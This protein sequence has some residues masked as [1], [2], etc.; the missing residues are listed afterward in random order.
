MIYRVVLDDTIDLHTSD[1]NCMLLNPS[2][3]LEMNSAGSF[4]FT[5]PPSHPYWD[6]IKVLKSTIDVYED[7]DLIFTGRIASIEKNWNNERVVQCEGALAYFNDSIHRQMKWETPLPIASEDPTVHN[8]LKDILDNHNVFEGAENANRHIFIGNITVDPEVVT[9]EV[10]YDTTLDILTRMCIDT[11][12]GYMSVR[13]DLNDGKLYLDWI[14]DFTEESG[15]PAQFGL[16]LLNFDTSL[17]AEDICTGVLAR[18]A[19]V[20][21]QTVMLNDVELVDET[22]YPDMSV[23]HYTDKYQD[24]LWHREGVEKFGQVVQVHDFSDAQTAWKD[25]QGQIVANSLFEMAKKW[26]EEKNT[27]IETIEVE[28]AELAW[29]GEGMPKYKLGQIVELSDDVHMAG[30]SY[31]TRLLPMYKLSCDLNSGSKKVT[32]GTPPKKELTQISASNSD[33]STLSSSGSSSGSGGSGEGEECRV[34]D[35]RVDGTSVVTNKIANI[36]LTG[37]ADVSTVNALAVTVASKADT[38]TVNALATVVASKQDQIE[39]NT[40]EAATEV[41]TRLKANNVVYNLGGG[42]EVEA[43]PSDPAT[44]DLNTIKIGDTVYDIPGSGGS[45]TN[46][47]KFKCDVLFNTP[48]TTSSWAS[49]I[50]ICS[51]EKAKE[52]DMIYLITEFVDGASSAF[53]SN[54]YLVNSIGQA[55]DSDW[56]MGIRSNSSWTN[57]ESF[58]FLSFDDSKLKFYTNTGNSSTLC[59]VYGLKFENKLINR[60]DIYSEE[61]RMIGRW[62]DGKPLYQKVLTIPNLPNAT[63]ADYPHGIQNVD[64][65]WVS[66]GVAKN[67][68]TGSSCQLNNTASNN[69][70]QW[71]TNADRTNVSIWAGTDRRAFDYVKVILKYTKTTDAPNSGFLPEDPQMVMMSDYYSEDEQ[72]IGRWTDGKPLY[73][74]VVDCGYGPNSGVKDVDLTALNVDNCI[75]IGGYMCA[76]NTSFLPIPRV[77]DR[78]IADQ[79][80]FNYNN[81]TKMLSIT[82]RDRDMT[83]IHIIAI[84]KYTKTTDAPGTGP[85]KGNLIYLPALYSEEEREVGVWTDGKPIYQKNIPIPAIQSAQSGVLISNLGLNID[86]CVDIKV[87]LYKDTTPDDDTVIATAG[88]GSMYFYYRKSEDSIRID[89]PFSW[90]VGRYGNLTIQYTKTTDQPGS[91]TWTPEGQLAHHYSTS[92]KIV[93]TWI[94]GSTI[95]EKTIDFGSDITVNN[96]WQTTSELNTNMDK[97]ISAIF[98]SSSGNHRTPPCVQLNYGSYIRICYNNMTDTGRYLTLQYTKSS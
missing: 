87:R 29:L 68:Q 97:C 71:V 98:M 58:I 76:S 26:L 6:A 46:Y 82:C 64:N 12:G 83:S 15:Q 3:D 56:M 74:K 49:P 44:D 16:N 37:K 36:S 54:S 66:D 32:L 79:L 42:T 18:G 69:V 52:Y 28:V 43:N 67:T 60:S 55:S 30:E 73:Q 10:N 9:R 65:I 5:L 47:G 7:G 84:L 48:T 78:Y 14:K 40:L 94:D 70:Y 35:V 38:S 27:K 24:V 95:Y 88:F 50:E 63:S 57:L 86:T 2:L 21:E 96:N 80:A 19:E 31:E 25:G 45:S 4:N 85:I 72:V 11:N 91:G 13:K 93:G 62:T 1:I 90:V 92:E 41:L 59:K 77:S 61:E 53:I 75:Q 81:S 23:T 17:A 8:F 34:H 89:M 20:N 33:S 39:F 22:T 51:E